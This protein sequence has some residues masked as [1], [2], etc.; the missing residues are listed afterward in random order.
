M[1]YCIQCGTRV[2]E[3]MYI[4][5]GPYCSDCFR[6]RY[7]VCNQCHNSFPLT[8]RCTGGICYDCQRAAERWEPTPVNVAHPT[9]S[10]IGSKRAFGV[11]I[12]TSACHN[13]VTTKG[14]HCF[15]AKFDSSIRGMEFISPILQG[16]Q[17]LQ[18]V[19]DFCNLA[20]QMGWHINSDCGLHIHCDMRGEEVRGLQNVAYAYLLTHDFWRLMVN[21]YRAHDC[22]YCRNVDYNLSDLAFN[23]S[24][25]R[26][27][28]WNRDRYGYCNLSAYAKFGSYEI[29]LHQGS[30]NGRAITAW[31]RVHLRFIDA[32]AAL[33]TM[34]D[35]RA[36]LGSTTTRQWQAFKQI[37]N[38]NYL[39]RYYGRRRTNS[40]LRLEPSLT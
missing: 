37:I 14:K 21:Q 30:L 1:P 19:V 15:G 3:A 9:Y 5:G 31:L 27:F 11:E 26:D 29:R 13:Y 2:P 16:D 22:H 35:V 33:H 10:V 12:E 25:W 39:I 38:D 28:C 7:F 40:L 20:Q 36:V 17:G 32:M 23:G 34:R 6:V 4:Y 8:Q 24:R 18:S